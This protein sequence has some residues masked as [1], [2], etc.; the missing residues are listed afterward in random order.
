MEMFCEPV[1]K[2]D[3]FLEPGFDA[4]DYFVRRGGAGSDAHRVRAHEP[5]G[6]EI[7]GSL[8][9]VYAPAVMSAGRHEFFRVITVGAANDDHGVALLGKFSGG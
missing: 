5:I 6:L 7:S 8:Y 9:V 4:I 1:L 3:Q 2:F